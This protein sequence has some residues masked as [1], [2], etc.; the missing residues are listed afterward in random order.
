MC[1]SSSGEFFLLH[2]APS[3]IPLCAHDGS[4][5]YLLNYHLP[6]ATYDNMP[7]RSYNNHMTKLGSTNWILPQQYSIQKKKACFVRS[8]IC[9]S[10]RSTAVF[11][12]V[13]LFHR[14]YHSP[15]ICLTKQDTSNGF[16]IVKDLHLSCIWG[17]TGSLGSSSYRGSSKLQY[18]SLKMIIVY[19]FFSTPGQRHLWQYILFTVY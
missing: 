3:I 6:V 2:S 15:M 14:Y 8:I 12:L 11:Y 17:L 19:F 10:N 16:R 13:S 1:I 5:I 9:S 7:S 18:D 4:S